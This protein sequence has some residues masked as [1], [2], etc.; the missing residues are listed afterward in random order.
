MKFKNTIH[1]RRHKILE[2]RLRLWR[3]ISSE[4]AGVINLSSPKKK[5]KTKKKKERKN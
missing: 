5:K 1:I 3:A 4:P 2:G